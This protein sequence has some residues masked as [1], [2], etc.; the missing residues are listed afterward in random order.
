MPSQWVYA[1]VDGNEAYTKTWNC[2]WKGWTLQSICLTREGTVREIWDK[3]E[4]PK[5][6]KRELDTVT[7]DDDEQKKK[8]AKAAEEGDTKPVDDKR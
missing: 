4:P 1:N 6:K 3:D 5:T 7:V 2:R 8:Q